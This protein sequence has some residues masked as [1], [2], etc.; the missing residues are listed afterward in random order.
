MKITE[1]DNAGEMIAKICHQAN[2]AFCETMDDWTQLDWTQLDWA[3]AYP[4]QKQSSVDGVLFHL[5]GVHSPEESHNNWMELK[6]KHGWK[7]GE[8]KDADKKT[9]P[10]MMRFWSLPFEQRMKDV[11]FRSIVHCFKEQLIREAKNK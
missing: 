1:D 8:I 9:H 2:K 5:N 4:W 10:C 3:D 6:I 11:L 7:Y